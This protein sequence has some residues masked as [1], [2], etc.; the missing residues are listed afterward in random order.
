M[1]EIDFKSVPFTP[2]WDTEGVD[3]HH[4]KLVHIC[5]VCG[6]KEILTA[7]EGFKYGWDYAP[8]MYPFRLISPRTCGSCSITDTVWAQISIHGKTFDE[9]TDVQQHTVGRILTEPQSIIYRHDE[10]LGK[11]G[12]DAKK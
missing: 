9:L 8:R 11:V 2:D 10:H 6:K 1:S 5:E 7:E 12:N 4:T 3:I